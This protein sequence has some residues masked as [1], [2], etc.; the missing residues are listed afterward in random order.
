[1]KLESKDYFHAMD[2]NTSIDAIGNLGV[3][4]SITQNQLR[5]LQAKILKGASAVELGFMGRGKGN[6]GQGA[7]TPGS[8]GK[9]EREA[10][11]DLSKINDVKLSVHASTGVGS[12]SGLSQN[13]FDENSR[14]QNILEGKRTIEFAADVA[15][16]GPIVVHTGEYPRQIADTPDKKLFEGFPTESSTGTGEE[17]KPGQKIHYIVDKRTGAIITGIRED[18]VNHIPAYLKEKQ[19]DPWGYEYHH[20]AWEGGDKQGGGK[21]AVD[22][23]NWDYYRGEAAKV[24]KG[25]NY[26]AVLFHKDKLKAQIEHSKGQAGEY[27]LQYFANKQKLDHLPETINTYKQSLTKIDAQKEAYKKQTGGK[28]D[29][30][31]N[32][33]E[34][35]QE[36]EY[37][38]RHLVDNPELNRKNI[39]KRMNYG[40]ETAASARAQEADLEYQAEQVASLDNYALT[41]TADSIARMALY[42]KEVQETNPNVNRDIFIAPENIWPEMGYGAHPDEL[43]NLIKISRTKMEEQLKDGTPGLTDEKAKDIASK[44]IKATFDIGHAHTWKKYFKRDEGES[45][46]NHH[47]RFTKWMMGK[48]EDLQKNNM[49]GHVHI[50]DN[51]GYYDEH[52][53]PGQGNV[54][55]KE[56]I[57]KLKDLGYKDQITIESA[58]QDYKALTEMWRVAN[59]P[60]YKID[61]T[62]RGWVDVEHGYFGHTRSPEFLFGPT[63]P[64]PR[65]WSPWSETPLE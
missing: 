59:S 43:K 7:T 9:D 2:R 25:D 65:T 44:H 51:F 31:Y 33:A 24:G 42:A 22:K 47:K 58:Q 48:V 52:I 49:L 19:E 6:M 11:R 61:G 56:F 23:R 28:L 16:G 37:E 13:R 64:D 27:E 29:G 46:E 15:G 50:T 21:L 30:F 39:I 26:A 32:F 55:V 4:T 62:S 10:M 20:V 53:S 14:E 57:D 40:K 60:I 41:K 45:F 8:Y 34:T 1:M 38:M 3:S 63:A 17:F 35:T 18:Q 12:W 36:R 54:P 5:E